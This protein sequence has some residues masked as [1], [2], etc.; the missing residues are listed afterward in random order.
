[1]SQQMRI[2][3]KTLLLLGILLLS[4]QGFCEKVISVIPRPVEMQRKEGAYE[5]KADTKIS[6]DKNKL[7]WIVEHGVFINTHANLMNFDGGNL[8]REEFSPN[9][10]R[11]F[12]YTLRPN[13]K[14]NIGMCSRSMCRAFG[15]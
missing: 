11:K 1:M 7:D 5:L 15:Q 10:A 3:I 12:L 4:Q 13:T 8:T 9:T 6:S 2:R 14:A